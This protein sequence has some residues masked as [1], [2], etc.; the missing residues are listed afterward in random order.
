VAKQQQQQQQQK[1][2]NNNRNNGSN[3]NIN[4]FPAA[5]ISAKQKPKQKKF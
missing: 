5:S 4:N 1:A 3:T 2:I